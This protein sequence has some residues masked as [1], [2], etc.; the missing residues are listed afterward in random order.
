V[1]YPLDQGQA[2]AVEWGKTSGWLLSSFLGA[3]LR[4]ALLFLE[5]STAYS[6]SSSHFDRFV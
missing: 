2:S 3:R 5:S 4:R 1:T 6:T